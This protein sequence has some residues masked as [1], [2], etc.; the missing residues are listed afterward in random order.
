MKLPKVLVHWAN[1]SQG[2]Y[3]HSFSSKKGYTSESSTFQTKWGGKRDNHLLIL[4]FSSVYLDSSFIYQASSSRS[5]HIHRYNGTRDRDRRH[6]GSVH[7]QLRRSHL[8]K[9]RK[10]KLLSLLICEW[11]IPWD[12]SCIDNKVA[13]KTQI[14]QGIELWMN[15]FFF[16][17]SFFYDITLLSPTRGRIANHNYYSIDE[18]AS[19]C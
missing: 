1:T 14:E 16:V 11:M 15:A 18:T 19:V 13:L 8:H 9:R 3:L 10:K 4:S 12:M 17:C 5:L 6:F 2:R 7:L